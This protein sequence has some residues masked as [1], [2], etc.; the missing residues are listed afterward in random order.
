V[1]LSALPKHLQDIENS[2]PDDE[3]FGT[4]T[5]FGKVY[6]WINKKTKTWFAFSYRCTEWWAKWR[7]Y[8]K[9]LL[10]IGGKGTWRYESERGD[11]RLDEIRVV[12]NGGYPPYLSRIQ[13]YKR[14]HFAIQWPFI[15]TFHC[16]FRAKDVPK[17]TAY[18]L[19]TD[20]TLLFFYL[21]HFDA[22]LVYWMFT[23][24]YIGFNWK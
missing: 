16:Y 12:F 6:R 15:I 18:S 3:Q 13:Y 14:W 7:K 23:S 2:F 10:A 11:V 17:S 1:P 5:L 22:D 24:A 4:K 19:D 8:P 20:G 21:N 9:V